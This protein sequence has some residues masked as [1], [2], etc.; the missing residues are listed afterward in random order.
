MP[1]YVETVNTILALGTIFLQLL[2]LLIIAGLIF[3]RNKEHPL[4]TF[5][6]KYTF[7]FG[8]AV[9]FAGMAL[10][11]FY[12]EFIGFPPCEL[13][14]VQRIF[15]YPQVLLFGLGLWKKN[16]K[17]INLSAALALLGSLV[18]IYHIYVE[19]GGSSS[20]ACV[21]NSINVVSCSARYVYEFGYVTIPVMALTT[22]VF[23]LLLLVNY[24]FVSKK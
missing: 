7:H 2:C 5:F 9:A 15:I 18:S 4:P 12:S 3:Y 10:S 1:D 6:K 13:C 11:L 16:S 24:R 20:L 19:N 21:T 23:I 14:I 22:Q 8:L 17:I